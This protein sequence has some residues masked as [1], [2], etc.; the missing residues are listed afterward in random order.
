M[1]ILVYPPDIIQ[2]QRAIQLQFSFVAFEFL[3][4][5]LIPSDPNM[6]TV[7]DIYQLKCSSHV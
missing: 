1:L 2:K 3:M 6:F 4:V 5:N 7:Y